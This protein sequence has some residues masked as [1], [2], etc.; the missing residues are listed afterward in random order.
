MHEDLTL[1]V[2]F[3]RTVTA[4]K[5]V[6][7]LRSDY[8]KDA[9]G[10]EHDTYWHTAL[11]ELSDGYRTE[12]KLQKS[13]EGQ[14]FDLGEH[15]TEWLKLSRLDPLQHDGSLNFAALNQIELWGRG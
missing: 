15:Q 11:I 14:V 10:R 1:A 13:A 8:N 9:Q 12:I 2:Y 7:C 6:L 4:D 5:L 3:G